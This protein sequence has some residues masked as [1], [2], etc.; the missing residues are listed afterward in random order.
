MFSKNVRKE[1]KVE[2]IVIIAYFASPALRAGTTGGDVASPH[3]GGAIKAVFQAYLSHG[4]LKIFH[5]C[6]EHMK[7]S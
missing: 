2:T 7:S 1:I 6:F 3:G 5:N 4:I